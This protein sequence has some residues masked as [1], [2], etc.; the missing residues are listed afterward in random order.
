MSPTVAESLTVR[1]WVAREH[2]RPTRF[3]ERTEGI[4]W[5]VSR[6][7]GQGEERR[8]LPGG[9]TYFASRTKALTFAHRE[10]RRYYRRSTKK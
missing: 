8:K 3:G 7:V 1:W 4:V 9:P 5:A 2:L 6:V 10:A